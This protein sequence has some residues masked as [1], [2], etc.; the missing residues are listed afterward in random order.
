[1]AQF[2][3]H[4]NTGHL[5]EEVPLLLVVQSA[6]F[7]DYHRRVVVPMVPAASTRPPALASLNPSFKLRG[8]RYLLHPLDIVSVPAERLGP[9]VGSLAAEGDRVVAALDELFSRAW[10]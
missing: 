9:K 6:Q 2:D 3:V 10:S 8:R 4:A 1:M 7:D 5:R